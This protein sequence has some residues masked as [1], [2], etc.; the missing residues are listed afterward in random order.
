MKQKNFRVRVMKYAHNL[1]ANA[2][3]TWS[4]CVKQAWNLYRL[5]L[6]MREDV[7][8]FLYRKTNGQFRYAFGTL[9]GLPAGASLNGKKVTKPSYKTMA[10]YDIKKQAMRCFRV[11]KLIAVY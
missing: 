5:A 8:Q 3:G 9:K 4:E 10:Y 1:W 7:V 11:E 2:Y 6:R